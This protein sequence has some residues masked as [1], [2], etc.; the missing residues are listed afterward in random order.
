MTTDPTDN[1]RGMIDRAISR[2]DDLREAEIRRVNEQMTLRAEYGAQ[3]A[4]AEAKRIDAIRAV[5][6]NAVSVANDRAT[7]QAAVLANQVS[8]SAETLRQLVAA[9]A[10]TVAGQL[11]QVSSEIANRLS[12]L[13]KAQYES[14]GSSGGMRD[15]WGWIIAGILVLIAIGGFAL[16]HLK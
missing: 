3:L 11:T 16:S 10:T 1:V 4:L 9:T 2:I 5:D 8:A 12:T 13:E 6:V 7:A 14:K 15:M